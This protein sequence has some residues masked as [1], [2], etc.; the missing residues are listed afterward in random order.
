MAQF[1]FVEDYERYVK[2][3]LET[4]P[5]DQAMELAVGGNYELLGQ[6]QAALLEKIGI[7]NSST[8]YD[9]GCGSGRLS[10]VLYQ[11]APNLNYVGVDVVRVLLEYAKIKAPNYRFI[12]NPELNI[13]AEN[14]SVDIISAF[15]LF[16]HLLHAESYIYLQEAHRVLKRGGGIIFSFL[17]FNESIHWNVFEQTVSTT[18]NQESTHLNM[19][20]ERNTIELWAKKLGFEVDMY[21]SATTPIWQGQPL[22][23][24]IAVLRKVS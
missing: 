20:I 9:L 23:Q 24:S 14:N 19:F 2:E 22:G 16:T 13:P 11:R 18:K 15:S 7:S 21:L 1:H 3:L 17:E 10:S 4:Y 6:V 12:L 5:L 8:I